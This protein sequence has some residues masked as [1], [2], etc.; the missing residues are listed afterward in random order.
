MNCNSQ[1]PEKRNQPAY[2]GVLLLAVYF[3]LFFLP[4]RSIAGEGEP[5]PVLPY[6][7]ILVFM[8]VQGV[9]NVQVPAAIRYDY[10][11]LSITDVF[12]FLKIRNTPSQGLDSITGFFL[13]AKDVF[14]IDNIN[15]RVQYNGKNIDLPPNSFIRNATSLYM[16]T[17]YF[18]SIFGLY[19]K[20][21]FRSL[22]VIL[23]TDLEL[24]VIREMRQE[25]MRNNLGRLKGQTKA[26]T[27]IR[28]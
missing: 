13:S 15:N 12:D 14:V 20:F 18:G 22:S 1:Y 11:Y 25:A 19:C 4:L 16:R 9:G 24:P 8:N 21:N 5:E 2:R 26:D 23:S 7:E 10:A 6:D 27:T 3:L 17:E 28:R